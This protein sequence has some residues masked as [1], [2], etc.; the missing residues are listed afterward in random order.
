[1]YRSYFVYSLQEH[2]GSILFAAL[3]Q[4]E[5]TAFLQSVC[6]ILINQVQLISHAITSSPKTSD[7][8]TKSFI[9]QHFSPPSQSKQSQI[10]Y[11]CFP[12]L[13]DMNRYNKNQTIQ[14]TARIT[15]SLAI[16]VL[17]LAKSIMPSKVA[18][19]GIR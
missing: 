14:W 10:N 16:A 2:N 15:I 5:Q 7:W 1:M 18:L 13:F 11:A 8:L 3:R 12:C 9:L 17:P 19:D 4:E 6:R